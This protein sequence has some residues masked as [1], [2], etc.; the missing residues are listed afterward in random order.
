[1]PLTPATRRRVGAHALPLTV[2]PVV[3]GHDTFPAHIQICPAARRGQHAR[4]LHRPDLFGNREQ[5]PRDRCSPGRRPPTPSGVRDTAS[6][7]GCRFGL[8]PLEEMS[9]SGVH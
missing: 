3:A 4:W 6:M 5:A 2:G 8:Y 7:I 1:M 9:S